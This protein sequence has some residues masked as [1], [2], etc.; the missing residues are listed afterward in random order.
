MIWPSFEYET[1]PWERSPESLALIPK[2]RRRKISDTYEAAVPPMISSLNFSLSGELADRVAQLMA[3]MTRFDATTNACGYNL[4]ASLLRSES[5]ASSQIENLT[6]SVRN[7]ALAELSQDAPNNAMLIAGNVAAMRV[8]LEI[9]DDCSVESI[10]DVHRAL[11]A[12]SGQGYGGELRS[13]QVWIDGTPCSPHGADYVA[14]KWERIPTL[15]EDLCSFCVRDDLNSIVQTAIAHA[16][17]ENIHPFIDGN[18]CCGRALIHRQLA[19]KGALRCGG[20]PISAG[21]LHDSDSYFRALSAYR[22]GDV[23]EIVEQL[24]QAIELALAIG[25]RALADIEELIGTW[26][27]VITE[28]KGAAIRLLPNLL[29]EQPVVDSEY[30]AERL[31][32]STRM[33][34]NVLDRAC[35]Y[36]ILRQL[37]SARRNRYFQCDALLAILEEIL[38]KDGIRRTLRG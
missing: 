4:P 6:A 27:D 28:R 29:A 8:A 33:A 19:S 34:R 14:P 22:D 3:D 38:S 26:C 11:V 17:F 15:L 13:E 18:G 37:G 7:V 32:I 1:C 12:P 10:L 21:L 2:S 36:G 31:S 35:E 5:S 23:A 16:Q 30:V 25:F 24:V 20:L 9:P